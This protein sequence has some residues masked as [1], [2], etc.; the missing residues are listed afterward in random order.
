MPTVPN[1]GIEKRGERATAQ[2]NCGEVGREVEVT[3]IKIAAVFLKY[4]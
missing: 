4:A 1:K 3:K 2:R